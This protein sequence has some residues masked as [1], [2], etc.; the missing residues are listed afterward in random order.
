MISEI[1]VAR[2]RVSLRWVQ[3][4]TKR[5]IL[6]GN[7]DTGHLVQEELKQVQA[8]RAKMKEVNPDD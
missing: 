8:E 4:Y 1:D 5:A 2:Q 6:A 3:G 7:W